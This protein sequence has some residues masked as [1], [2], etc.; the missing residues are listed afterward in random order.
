MIAFI[1]VMVE[2]VRPLSAASCCGGGASASL[3][4]P[5]FATFLF[6]TSIEHEKYNGY[7]NSKGE[8][9]KDPPGSDLRQLRLSIGSAY[10]VHD[11][12]QTFV[13]I[14][15]VVNINQ[16]TGLKST[17]YGAGDITLGFNFELFNDIRC[18]YRILS[19]EDIWPATYLGVKAIVP[20]GISPYDNVPNSFDITG[21][22][23][24]T[25]NFSLLLDKTIK[26][27]N[28][29]LAGNYSISA[30]RPVNME[31]G[32][33]IEPYY[34]QPGGKLNLTASTGYT[35]SFDSMDSITGTLGYGYT[36]EYYLKINGI[37]NQNSGFLKHNLLV[38]IAFATADQNNVI[39]FNNAFNLPFTGW[40]VNKPATIITTLEYSH[41][42]R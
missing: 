10:R 41:V 30:Q 1:A 9:K 26:S 36:K 13:S 28:I 5:K 29:S 14:P 22:G 17:T 18:V 38:G 6:D 40:G 16:Y 31:Y 37:E 20:T 32:R 4:L 2:I 21:L 24:Y 42:F 25:F 27:F 33:Y 19:L 15:Y 3:V 39:K 12:I 11:N 8:Y 35:F 7:W 23:F 34:I